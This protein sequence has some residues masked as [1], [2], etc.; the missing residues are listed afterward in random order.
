M[1]LGV[2]DTARHRLPFRS[3]REKVNNRLYFKQL[4]INKSSDHDDTNALVLLLWDLV[5][6]RCSE[7]PLTSEPR[8][9]SG[10]ATEIQSVSQGPQISH[11]VLFPHS[12][13]GLTRH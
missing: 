10:A 7:S 9:C 1:W 5:R 4:Q 2:V 13:R 3:R 6:S 11:I 8:H 12:I